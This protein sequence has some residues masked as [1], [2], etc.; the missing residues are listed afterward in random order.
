[1]LSDDTKLRLRHHGLSPR[2]MDLL[3][4]ALGRA[5]VLE[6]ARQA[7]LSGKSDSAQAALHHA[8]QG[9]D[10]LAL[11]LS[12]L[13]TSDPQLKDLVAAYGMMATA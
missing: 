3:Q 1:M 13:V 9:G 8:A 6:K 10:P 4:D 5:A 2:E 11:K 12:T 7:R